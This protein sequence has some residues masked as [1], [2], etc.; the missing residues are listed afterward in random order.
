[1]GRVYLECIDAAAIQLL[2]GADSVNYH[3]RCFSLLAPERYLFQKQLCLPLAEPVAHLLKPKKT[4]R[5][6]VCVHSSAEWPVARN[7]V[8]AMGGC[9]GGVGRMSSQCLT[10]ERCSAACPASLQFPAC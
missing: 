1:M 9:T 7:Q 5:S 6:E 2:L 4:G 10:Y 8:A 3:C